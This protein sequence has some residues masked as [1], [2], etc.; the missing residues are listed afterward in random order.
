MAGTVRWTGAAADA[1]WA[2]AGNWASVSG[3][4]ATPPGDDDVIIF[5]ERSGSNSTITSNL[6]QSARDYQRIEFRPGFGLVGGSIGASGSP[7]ICSVSNTSTASD[8][9]VVFSASGATVYI[10]GSGE[11]ID[12]LRVNQTGNGRLVLTGGTVTRTVVESGAV[13]DVNDGVVLTTVNIKGGRVIDND[14][15]NTSTLVEVIGGTYVTKRPVTTLTVDGGQSTS[16]AAATVGTLN[17]GGGGRHVHES[18]GTVTTLNRRKGDY[19]VRAD[20]TISTYNNYTKTGNI[21]IDPGYNDPTV[22]ATTPI[23]DPSFAV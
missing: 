23:G 21:I 15:S 10:G 12:E 3:T 4:P 13:V 20:H 17:V 2:T 22:S 19:V 11:T 16:K 6:D 9:M 1:D 18:T 8:P 7:L 5:D 14:N